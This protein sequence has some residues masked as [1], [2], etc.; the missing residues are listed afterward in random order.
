MVA[1]SSIIPMDERTSYHADR[2]EHLFTLK[3]AIDNGCPIHNDMLHEAIPRETFEYWIIWLQVICLMIF[4]IYTLVKE[5]L[6]DELD[7]NVI[8]V[9]QFFRDN[10]IS[11]NVEVFPLAERLEKANIESCAV[12]KM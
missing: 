2:H 3:L 6:K 8:E 10:H 9:L 12:V 5:L 7:V 11:W 4:N 1:Q